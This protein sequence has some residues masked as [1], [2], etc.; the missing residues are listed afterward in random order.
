[1]APNEV[2]ARRA[3]ATVRFYPLPAVN[4]Q[5]W[6]RLYLPRGADRLKP[7]PL[8]IIQYF[9]TPGYEAGIGDEVPVL[10]LVG[11]GV[12]VF[13]MHSGNL[14]TAST[15]GDFRMQFN[16]LNRPLKGMESIIRQLAAEGIVDPKHVGVW[17]LSYGAE[18]AVYAAW[19]SPLFNAVSV[20]S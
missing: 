14:N 16:R 7:V 4:E 11:A 5:T 2:F 17:G 10:P 12:A 6:G 19:R 9:S 3:D 15:T 20:A 1:V 18:I 8:V 13:A